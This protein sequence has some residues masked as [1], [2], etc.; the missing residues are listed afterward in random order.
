[1]EPPWQ[2]DE[3]VRLRFDGA[4]N[5]VTGSRFLLRTEHARVLFECGL[6]QGSRETWALNRAPFGFDPV[7]LDAV[8]LTH[9]HLD[10]S[11]LLPRLVQGDFRGPIHA[12]AGTAKLAEI[13]LLDAAHIQ[14]SDAKRRSRRN[15]R[16]GRDP[17]EPLYRRPDA[18]KALAQIA[19]APFGERVEVA[20]GV[21]VRFRPAGHILGAAHVEVFVQEDDGERRIVLSGDVG[22]EGDPLVCDPDPPTAADLVLLESTYGDR[23]HRDR[24]ATE[25]ELV[26]ILQA[27][28][29]SGG[30]VLIPV[31]AVGRAQ[32]VLHAI[33]EFERRGL[34]E[35]RRVY[36][37]SPMAVDVTHLY[38][39]REFGCRVGTDGPPAEIA[40]RKLVFTRNWE[41][42]MQI[43]FQRGV[44]VLAASGMC[45]AGRI[46]HHLKHQLWKPDSHI[47]FTGYQAAGTR[48]R[49]IVD[50][51]RM[52]RV[53]GEDIAVK[54]RV[55][56]LGGFSA[57][58][59][60]SELVAWY[61][62]IAERPP[63]VLIHGETE[64][65]AT[66]ARV[67]EERTGVRAAQPDRGD[68][69]VLR[70]GVR[71]PSWSRG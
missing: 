52:I 63:L 68:E 16:R 53:L 29:E 45:D 10:H 20:P 22:R 62:G 66:L 18:E 8:V 32:S 26:E 5:E 40:T 9:A 61:D 7:Q 21:A 54:A 17:V 59:G 27:T 33:G 23:D 46:L 58:A 25:A 4:A 57:H 41:D 44:I 30:N 71:E 3:L 1:M 64:K 50:G 12:T 55:H 67:I 24:A 43:N 19:P 56:T 35:P 11:G 60:Q 15:L 6:H 37:D 28:A 65:R 14:E 38:R 13:L 51:A 39:S 47:V 70:R 69:L 31:F 42:S 2:P 34:I 36:L 48:G 49:A